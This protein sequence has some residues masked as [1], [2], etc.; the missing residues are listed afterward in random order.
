[1]ASSSNYSSNLVVPID[2]LVNCRSVEKQKLEF[3]KSWNNGPTKFQIIKTISAFANDFYNDNGG[4]IIIGVA[5]DDSEE[6]DEQIELP[7]VGIKGKDLERIQKEIF[8]ACK[9]LI[10]P[11]Y[12]PI[13]SPEVVQGKHVLVIWAQASDNRPHK[14]RVATKGDYQYFIR[15]GPETTQASDDE[16]KVLLENAQKI[17]FDDRMARPE[18]ISSRIRIDHNA[19]G[20][21]LVMAFLDDVGSCMER[22]KNRNI[23][24]KLN[25][26]VPFGNK[27][28][29]GR[30][31]P[32]LM[33]KNVALL[34][35]NR[36]PHEYFPGAKIEVTQFTRDNTVIFSSEKEFTGP[37]QKQIKECMDY[38]FSTTKKEESISLVTYPHQAL[39][40]SIVNAVYHR[41]YEPE[42]DSSTKVYIRPHCL[43]IISYPGPHPSL[44]EE[45][46]TKGSVPPVQARNRRIGEFLRDLCL[47][48]ARNTGI[49]TIFRT[50]ENNEN[51][52]PKF[53]FD[54]TYFRVTLP[55]HPKFQA[56]MLMKEVQELEAG[57]KNLEASEVLQKAFD[58]DP[59]IISQRLIQQ[60]ITL[61]G[62]N[63]EHPT[64]KKYERYIE[65][66]T[67]KRCELLK[68]LGQWLEDKELA[69]SSIPAGVLLVE[70]LIKADA[71]VDELSGVTEFV[72]ELC[73]ERTVNKRRL[74]LKSNQAAHQ[75]LEAYGRRLIS[76]HGNLAYH[77]ACTKYNIFKIKT[78]KK[79]TRSIL[80]RNMPILNYLVDARDLL[81][82]AVRM[83]TEKEDPKLFGEQQRQLGYIIGNLHHFRKARNSDMQECFKKAVEAYPNIKINLFEVNL[84]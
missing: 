13:V 56:A 19:I 74:K 76:Q 64:V 23:L 65:A 60:L 3:K 16:I 7:P 47:A 79:D 62:N 52:I 27:A 59:K 75:L 57:G 35:F 33:P 22:S 20:Y 42:H 73:T 31:T 29:D 61:L 28:I 69:R 44:K 15:K 77:F 4:Y 36:V 30:F 46:F 49:Q 71:D 18:Y 82:N 48:E 67:K 38:V 26:V 5:E 55:A 24:Q 10:K 32:V 51:P 84:K 8:G 40:E 50:M 63:C 41:G 39:R 11:L 58:K 21:R 54:P 6:T 1:M 17:P 37:L 81:E 72:C 45:D 2:D 70:K 14:A 34:M 80:G 9:S 78:D 12:V 66:N 43:E 83:S 53:D 68:E 25:L